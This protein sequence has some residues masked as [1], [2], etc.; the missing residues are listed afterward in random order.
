MQSAYKKSHSTETALLRVQNDILMALDKTNIV[1]LVLLDLSAAFDTIDH[2]LLLARM[3]DTMGV[4]GTALSWF[5]SYLTN[6]QQLVQ[7]C[8]T[9]SAP[10]QLKYGVPQG[11]VLGPILFT[12]YTSPLGSIIRRHN[13]DYHLYADDTQLYLSFK[14]NNINSNISL[15]E[16]AIKEIHTWMT[17]NFLKLN[18][19]KTELLF[20]GSRNSLSKLNIPTIQINDCSIIPTTSARNLGAQFDNHMNMNNHVNSVCKSANFHIRNISSIRKYLNE[21]TTKHLVHTFVTSRID[22]ANSLLCG[23]TQVNINKLQLIQNTSARLITKTKKYDHVTDILYKL[24]WLPIKQRIDFKILL[25]TFL[26]I[27][28][29]APPY[30]RD[31]LT[32]YQPSRSLRSENQHLLK[33]RAFNTTFG[34][35]TFYYAAPKLWNGLP[36]DVKNSNTVDIFKQK[37]KTYLFKQAFGH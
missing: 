32:Q 26:A 24:H 7:I 22:Y 29:T 2:S 10:K 6:R 19:D 13:I 31:L 14:L 16:S 21:G 12:L 8:K 35:R 11:S 1:M 3:S 33:T 4:N 30:I 37:L 34:K 20:F 5:K 9:K 28:G 25:L 23:I 18:S 27:H 17:D 36:L 15:M